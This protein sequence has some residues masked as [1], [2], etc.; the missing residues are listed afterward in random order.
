[1]NARILLSAA[2]LAFG[3]QMA[4]AAPVARVNGTDITEAE[5]AFAEAEVGAEIAGLPAESRRRVLVEYLVEAHLF[6]SEATKD[7]LDAAKDFEERAAYYKL[8]ALRDTF[9]EKKVR[10]AITDAQAKAAYDEQIAKL[11]PEPEV[12]ARHILVKTKEEAADLVKQLKG[13][14]DFNE[15]AKK[16]ADGPSAN[17]GGDLGYFSKGQMVKVFEDTAFALQPGQIS[18]PVQSEFGWHVIKVEDKR[19]RPVPSFDEVKDQIVASLVQ[20]QL[21]ETV[22]KL[23]SSAKVEIV[24]PE[25][26]KAIEEDAKAAAIETTTQQK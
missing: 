22:Q 2:V 8:R 1:M 4:Q 17:T 7:K 26:K 16:S 6:A 12:R 21:R 5:I 9:Y 15:L 23:R 13:G 14:A 20:N 24:D 19:N 18:D 11:K 3:A 25:L 10:D